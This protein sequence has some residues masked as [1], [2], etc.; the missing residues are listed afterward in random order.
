MTELVNN[1]LLNKKNELIKV[2][3]NIFVA[4]NQI[5]GFKNIKEAKKSQLIKFIKEKFTGT[6]NFRPDWVNEKFESN[7]NKKVSG[8]LTIEENAGSS[9]RMFN[10]LKYNTKL[11]GY[12]KFGIDIDDWSRCFQ[13]VL[14]FLFD[15]NMESEKIVNKLEEYWF[16]QNL[17]KNWNTTFYIFY[18]YLIDDDTFDSIKEA[19]NSKNKNSLKLQK[20]ADNILTIPNLCNSKIWFANETYISFKKEEKIKY[21]SLNFLIS[22]IG[23]N[24][25]YSIDIKNF[26]TNR[27]KCYQNWI[28]KGVNNQDMTSEELY[29]IVCWAIEC[30]KNITISYG[31]H[32]EKQKRLQNALFG[33]TDMGI[34]SITFGSTPVRKKDTSGVIYEYNKTIYLTEGKN[35]KFKYENVKIEVNN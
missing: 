8:N 6:D 2:I 35:P 7:Y 18:L 26:I 9:K 33:G 13:I 28:N 20:I 31:N 21:N 3:A 5:Y 1:K 29:Y 19:R 10:L 22:K 23:Y 34:S 15:L 25:K 16:W 12:D 27:S 4:K 17:I 24:I 11:H 30:D 32:F 14:M